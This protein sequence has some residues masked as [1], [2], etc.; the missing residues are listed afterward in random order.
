MAESHE[1]G[2]GVSRSSKPDPPGP[3]A[4]EVLPSIHE[5]LDSVPARSRCRCSS[6]AGRHRG[7]ADRRP[8]LRRRGA[9]QV[10][11]T[12]PLGNVTKS[13]WLCETIVYMSSA[14]DYFAGDPDN[15]M[16]QVTE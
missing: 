14:T 1:A 5:G 15:V 11:L 9:R 6:P 7:D 16:A 10:A 3:A 12:G 13:T 2:T 8:T 4:V